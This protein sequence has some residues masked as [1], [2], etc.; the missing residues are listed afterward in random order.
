MNTT[1]TTKKRSSR[2]RRHRPGN[3]VTVGST[4]SG[5]S[6]GEVHRIVDAAEDRDVA[7]VAIDPHSRSLVWNTFEQLIARGHESR[8]I[9]DQLAYFDKVPGYRFLRPSTAENAYRRASENQQTA[10]EF[11]DVLTRRRGVDSSSLSRSPQ[12]EEWT[13]KAVMFALEQNRERPGSDLQYAF[14][15]GHPKFE[16]LLR[17]CTDRDL[18]FEFE[19]IA[20]GNIKRGQYAA[21]ERL[22][23][24]TCGSAAFVAR[25]GTSLNFDA[26]LDDCGI[27]LVEGSNDGISADAMQ[28]IMGALVLKVIAYVR[29][30]KKSTPRVLL[31]L[32]ECTNAQLVSTHEA[33]AMA[34]LQKKALDCH[35]LVQLLDFPSTKITDA[36]LSNAVRHEWYYNANSAVIR[37][38]IEDLGLRSPKGSDGKLIDDASSYI[39]EL[40]VGERWVKYRGTIREKV[41]RERVPELKN[42]WVFPRLARKKAL[43]ALARIRERPEYQRPGEDG[44]DHGEEGGTL[45]QAPVEG[46]ADRA[47]SAAERV[48][49][50]LKKK[51]EGK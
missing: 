34:E 12:T 25:C 43:E 16:A 39:R 10:H 2:R 35:A 33:K 20:C 3:Q 51:Q 50:R 11:T 32:D 38:A 13:H 41:W 15:V 30:R 19:Q 21:A 37:R 7:I 1:K 9:L 17:G 47:M 46:G 29:R 48:R 45:P 5:K 28:T 49:E 26:F 24:G 4:R 40:E 31:V 36:V 44:S 22:I 14:K 18:K 8:V 23:T 42:P 6:H 27:L